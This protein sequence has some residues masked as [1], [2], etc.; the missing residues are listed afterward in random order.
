MK[1]SLTILTVLLLSALA[2]LAQGT[3]NFSTRVTGTVVGHVYGVGPGEAAWLRKTGNTAT[4]TPAGTQTYEGA[5]LTGSGFSAQLW[6]ANGANQPESALMAIPGSIVS[7]RTGGTLGGTPAP[8]SALSVPWIPAGGTGTFQ[9]RAWYNAG[10]I[11][12]SWNQSIDRGRSELFNVSNLGDGIL[13]LPANLDNFRSFSLDTIPEPSS[14]LLLALGGLGLWLAR[15]RK[16]L[17]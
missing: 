12:T 11:F 14:Y 2:A 6:A 9:V 3:V 7:F 1:N 17:V 16:T 8:I 15:R 13:T 4:E 5:F 10:G